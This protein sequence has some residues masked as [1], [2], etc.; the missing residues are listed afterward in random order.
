MSK[1]FFLSDGEL[2]QIASAV[3]ADI[4]EAREFS[5]IRHPEFSDWDEP[6][7]RQPHRFKSQLL[8]RLNSEPLTTTRLS[9]LGSINHSELGPRLRVFAEQRR[10]ILDQET[11]DALRGDDDLAWK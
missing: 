2:D 4:A 1:E 7:F 11:I 5:S 8:F 3:E 6:V 10:Q 9:H